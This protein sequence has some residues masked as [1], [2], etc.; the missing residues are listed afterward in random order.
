VHH[1]LEDGAEVQ[2]HIETPVA[3]WAGT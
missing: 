2:F 3:A 1:T